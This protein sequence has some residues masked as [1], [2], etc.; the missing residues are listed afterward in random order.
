MVNNSVDTP[1]SLDRMDTKLIRPL[2]GINEIDFPDVDQR[3]GLF[4]LALQERSDPL[5]RLDESLSA[6]SRLKRKLELV[7]VEMRKLETYKELVEILKGLRSDEENLKKRT[8]TQSKRSI[9][10]KLK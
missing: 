3:L 2:K 9:I 4:R 5:N 6:L 10:D 7:L 8:E 1:D